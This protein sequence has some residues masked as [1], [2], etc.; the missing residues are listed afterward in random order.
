MRIDNQGSNWIR[1]STRL[2]IYA[3]DGFCC[4]YCGK[5][6]RSGKKT[7]GG[8]WFATL[9][10]LHP[11]ELGGDSSPANLVT[12]CSTCNATKGTL[13][14]AKFLGI[15]RDKGIDTAKLPAH[16]RQLTRTPLDRA[17]GRRLAAAG[18]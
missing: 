12:A 5:K 18:K 13:P 17:E 7:K 15:L 2:A 14:L 8:Q 16:I 1:R 11:V 4:A 9:D 10:H 6:V 3:R